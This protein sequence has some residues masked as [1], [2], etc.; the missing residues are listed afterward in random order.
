MNKKSLKDKVLILI[1]DIFDKLEL[2]QIT[3][4]IQNH[5]VKKILDNIEK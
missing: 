3:Q 4:I 5:R 2:N 1:N